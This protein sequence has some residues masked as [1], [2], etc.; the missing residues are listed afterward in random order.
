MRLVHITVTKQ[1]LMNCEIVKAENKS[2]NLVWMTSAATLIARLFL[3][4]TLPFVF[5]NWDAPV[6]FISKC[7]VNHASLVTVVVLKP[8]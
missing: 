5:P 1:L 6:L 7:L 3:V 2:K 4:E 8:S